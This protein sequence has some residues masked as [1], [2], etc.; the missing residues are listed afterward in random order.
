MDN[1]LIY[2]DAILLLTSLVF[3]FAL[4]NIIYIDF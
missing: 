1:I 4:K 3:S 2:S